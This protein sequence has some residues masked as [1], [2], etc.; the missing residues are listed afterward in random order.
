MTS[1]SVP[2][3]RYSYRLTRISVLS[4]LSVIGSFIHLPGPVQTV[5]FDS[6]PGFFAALFYGPADGAVVCGIGHM[7]TAIVNGFPLG[8]L[9]LPIAL[10]LA[11]AGAAMGSF[12]RRYGVIPGAAIGITI[13]TGLIVTAIP[14]LGWQ[15]TL[16]F[17]PFLAFAAIANALVASFVYRSL[18]G[19]IN[20]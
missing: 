18:K 3:T 1:D 20:F 13:N 17:L 12:N 8:V 7:A 11:L 2:R 10:G 16:S 6:A 4:A 5:A 14:V 15:A 9:H 19:R